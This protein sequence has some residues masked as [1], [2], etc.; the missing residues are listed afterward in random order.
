[1]TLSDPPDV[2]IIYRSRVCRATWAEFI[3]AATPQFL[4]Y[5]LWAQP[6]YGGLEYLLKNAQGASSTKVVGTN[7][8]RTVLGSWNYS[9]KACYSVYSIPGVD[10]DPESAGSGEIGA[11]TPWQ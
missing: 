7:T 2:G 5:Q 6:Q 4:G 9:V 8:Y 1:V 11:C 3:T 10:P